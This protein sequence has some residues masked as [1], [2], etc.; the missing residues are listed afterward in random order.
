[1]VPGDNAD[2]FLVI[3][4][5]IIIIIIITTTTTTTTTII[6]IVGVIMINVSAL[7]SALVG[8]YGWFLGMMLVLLLLTG[9]TIFFAVLFKRGARFKPRDSQTS[10]FY[11]GDG[12]SYS[13]T[14]P[15]SK[16]LIFHLPSRPFSL[17]CLN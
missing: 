1:M 12:G 7:A 16:L 13:G 2:L 3:T 11:G 5:I 15:D 14:Y 6:I 17:L 10:S 4:I 9:L 8:N